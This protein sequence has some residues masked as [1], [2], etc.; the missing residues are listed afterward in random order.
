MGCTDYTSTAF[1]CRDYGWRGHNTRTEVNSVVKALKIPLP[2][3]LDSD[4]ESYNTRGRNG[5]YLAATDA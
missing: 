1:I 3:L 2:G 5:L 4:G